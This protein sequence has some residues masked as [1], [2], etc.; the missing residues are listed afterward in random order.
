M[1]TRKRL[2][3]EDASAIRTYVRLRFAHRGEAEMRNIQS[4]ILRTVK[5]QPGVRD[6]FIGKVNE[7]NARHASLVSKP[8]EDGLTMLQ[9]NQNQHL[10]EGLVMP[11]GGDMNAVMRAILGR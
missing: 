11:Y 4:R 5:A 6:E 3:P 1:P 8:S 10:I 9:V 7:F 2:S